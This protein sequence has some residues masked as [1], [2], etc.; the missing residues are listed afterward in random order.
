MARIRFI[1]LFL[2]LFTASL[3]M[4]GCGVKGPPTL[5]EKKAAKA[6]NFNRLT[7]SPSSDILVDIFPQT[8]V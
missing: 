4:S 2:T 8:P 5:P 7:I 6:Y 1:F 3:S